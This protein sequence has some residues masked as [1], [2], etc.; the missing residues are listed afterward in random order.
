MKKQ[1]DLKNS[2]GFTLLEVM[3]AIAIIAIVFTVVFRFHSQTVSMNIDAGFDTTAPLLA[4][5]LIAEMK[6]RETRKTDGS[7]DFGDNFPGWSYTIAITDVESEALG[8]KYTK[9]LKKINVTISSESGREF[10]VQVYKFLKDA[11]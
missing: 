10:V 11:P 7:G 1:T 9:D 8:E 3:V 2:N 5:K 4:K 6:F